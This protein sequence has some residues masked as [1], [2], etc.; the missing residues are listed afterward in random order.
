MIMKRLVKM[1]RVK[2]AK[3]NTLT[4]PTLSIRGFLTDSGLYYDYTV[5]L[6]NQTPY[7]SITCHGNY[8]TS[9]LY[10]GNDFEKS[11]EFFCELSIALKGVNY[12][13][14]FAKTKKEVQLK[15]DKLKSMDTTQ[16]MSL[17][18][19][20]LFLGDSDFAVC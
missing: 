16:D 9:S 20:P 2:T 8:D 5:R 4:K 18:K 7:Y 1:K 17:K 14:T 3:T 6:L 12:A 19:K 11:F 10:D 15:V 13:E